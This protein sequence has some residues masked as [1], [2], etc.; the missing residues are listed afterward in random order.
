MASDILFYNYIWKIEITLLIQETL[1]LIDHVHI[2]VEVIQFFLI[3][4][5]Y[6]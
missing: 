3:I 6:K 2:D 5:G 1:R 4:L